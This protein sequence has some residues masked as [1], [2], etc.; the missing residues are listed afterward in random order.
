MTQQASKLVIV[1]EKLLLKEIA[2]I[3]DAAGATGYTVMAAGGKGRR[4]IRGTS[5]ARVVDELGYVKI[6]VVTP[7][8]DMADR[9]AN[10][11]VEKFLHD[12]S[13]IAYF[14]AVRVVR[15]EKFRR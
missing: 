12:Y 11:V 6:E 1:T 3:I 8:Q 14:E 2:K 10:N 13:G 7:D 5:R 9:I 4:D 15:R